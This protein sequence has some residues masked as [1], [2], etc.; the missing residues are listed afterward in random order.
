[1]ST[2]ATTNGHAPDAAPSAT[3]APLE[4]T[5]RAELD[6][7][8]VDVHLALPAERVSAALARLATLGYTPRH[9]APSPAPAFVHNDG[10]PTCPAHGT[11]KVKESSHRPG[12]FFCAAKLPDGSFCKEKPC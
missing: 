8:P 11:A 3:R 10:P 9:P 4:L 1:M 7:W 2:S 6:G 5:V 12:T